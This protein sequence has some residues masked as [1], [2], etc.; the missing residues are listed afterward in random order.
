MDVSITTQI[1]LGL[2]ALVPSA[3]TRENL[4]QNGCHQLGRVLFMAKAKRAITKTRPNDAPTLTLLPRCL[5][6]PDDAQSPAS[7]I[8]TSKKCHQKN[9]PFFL[10]IHDDHVPGQCGHGSLVTKSGLGTGGG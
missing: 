2:S 8:K 1:P 6:R 7:I 5:G 3:R 9:R 4:G 10:V